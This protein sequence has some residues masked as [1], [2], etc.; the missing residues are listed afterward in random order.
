MTLFGEAH[1]FSD[2]DRAGA[3]DEAA[4]YLRR[5]AERFHARRVEVLKTLDLGVGASFLDAGCG[6]G[7]LVIEAAAQV[8][9]G[10]FAV[11][12]DLSAELIERAQAAA[13]SSGSNAVFQVGD[14]TRL[15]FEDN[16]F[17][18]VRCERVLQHL[19]EDA[20]TSAVKEFV[21][22]AKPGGRVYVSDAVHA[23]HVVDCGDTEVFEAVVRQLKDSVQDPYAGIRLKRRL[24]VAGATIT[25]WQ[26]LVPQ[27]DYTTWS[28]A[29][30][31][32]QRLESLVKTG[33]VDRSRAAAF[34]ADLAERDAAGNFTAAAFACRALAVKT[35]R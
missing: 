22:V 17:D 1:A 25:S 28:Q 27:M 10:G 14:V 12:V 32:E 5:M 31:L 34:V 16:T 24:E 8:G 19:A 30:G 26:M 2:V 7:E 33:T 18:A 21:R 4:A 13:D 15:R 29:L 11:G 9:P 6:L 23:T 3:G 35:S 20:A